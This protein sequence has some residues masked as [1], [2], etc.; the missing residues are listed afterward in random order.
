MWMIRV[1]PHFS[2]RDR[3]MSLSPSNMPPARNQGLPAM[4]SI[5]WASFSSSL[6]LALSPLG[7]S[8]S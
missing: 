7:N 5:F 4:A 2:A 8:A 3:A 1:S 6:A